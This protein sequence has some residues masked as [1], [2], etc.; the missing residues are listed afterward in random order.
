MS[1]LQ[2]IVEPNTETRD[3][4]GWCHR[5]TRGVFGAPLV[6]GLNS[7]TKAA[8]ATEYRHHTREMPDV[9]VPVW[10]DHVGD[11]DG[12]GR[13]NWGHVVSW[14]PFVGLFLSSPGHA[15]L[16]AFGR[17]VP[18]QQWFSS[19]E[20]IERT[21]DAQ[22]RFWSED[23]NG[24]RVAQPATPQHREEED[25]MA[26]YLRATGNSSPIDAKNPGTSRIW[27]GDNRE[28]G[29]VLYSGVWERSDDGTVRRLFPGEWEAIQ[30]AYKAAGR[31][32]PVADISGNELE[33]MY[34]IK[35]AEPKK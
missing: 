7:A 8:D 19:I 22:F 35:R 20:A 24:L 11:Y 6:A 34:L 14:I 30:A 10:F 16:D 27:A 13:K 32:V 17:E 15:K 1:T 31:A 9:A 4:T 29:G 21:F 5:H 23:I 25:I 2:Q 26:T 33:K 28:I 3:F 18:S 12:T